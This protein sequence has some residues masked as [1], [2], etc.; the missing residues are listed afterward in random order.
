MTPEAQAL[1]L[2]AQKAPGLMQAFYQTP[3]AKVPTIALLSMNIT[4][5]LQ[6]LGPALQHFEAKR[7]L[8][9]RRRSDIKRQSAY[10]RICKNISRGESDTV[11]GY[12]DA[13]VSNSSRD[14]PSTP[15]V[16]LKRYLAYHYI[17][18]AVDELCTRKVWCACHRVMKGMPVPIL[19][20]LIALC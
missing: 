9:L 5:R 20:K 14:I 8:Q 13:N 4:H 3:T 6:H 10:N 11:E 12:A 15:T 17:V 19:G 18:L 7:Y 16:S 2:W 1:R